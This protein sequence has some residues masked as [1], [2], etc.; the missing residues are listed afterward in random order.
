MASQIPKH[1]QILVVGGGPAGSYTASALAREGLDVV[2]LEA[3]QFPRYHIG[4]SLIP[5][6]RHYLRFIDAEQKLVE[7]GFK[8]KPGAAMKFNRFKREGYTDFVALGH[9][10]SSWNVVR[11]A[12]DKMLLD[13]ATSCGTKVF[14]RTRVNTFR[15][16]A[17]E[18]SRPVTAEWLCAADGETGV[19]SFDYL[20]D[21]SGRSGLM[22]TKYLHNRHL[23]ASLK[24]IALWGYW[25]GVDTYG[26]NTPRE[27][28]P[29]FETLTDESGWAW[30]IPLHDG[31][32][33]IG[34]VMNQDVYNEKVR[35]LK[36]SSLENRYRL[37]ITLAPALVKLIG[38]G[39][40]VPKEAA[41]E[42]PGQLDQLV[43]SASDFSYSASSYGGP[44]FRLVGDAGAFIDPFFSSG[45]HLA[46]TSAL[47][48][49]VSIC[50]AVRGDCSE[51][52]AAAWHTKRF[53]LSYTRFQIVV[54]SAYQQ[55]RST[56]LDILSDIDEDNYDRAF[57]AIRPVIQ[58]A[59]EM[60]SRLSEKELQSALQFCSKCFNPTSPEH[61]APHSKEALPKD[62][63]DVTAPL[64]D[65]HAIESIIS[66]TFKQMNPKGDQDFRRPEEDLKLALDQ[67]NGRRVVHREYAINNLEAEDVNGFVVRL[68]R[69]HLG[70]MRT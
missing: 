68:R 22:S 24:N 29:W 37:F 39:R 10:N 66:K 18:P 56:D 45:I 3:A 64:M 6:V 53:S 21:A 34:V 26:M 58:G 36:G 44:G 15:F 35:A 61:L 63:F 16:S 8:H 4:E 9:T 28:A 25:A 13:H 31:T 2:L 7:M 59:S 30:F 20:V 19:I 50:A 49:A 67:I 60:G 33:S 54:M 23:N 27:G 48:A 38:T 1:A 65:P 46:T 11:S 47:S 70:L 14:E 43:R 62:M 52:E 32:T 57:A 55:I 17:A 69:G 42:K 51:A 5:S 40:I 12:F 41:G